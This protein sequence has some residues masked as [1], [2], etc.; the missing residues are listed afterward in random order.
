[1]A[2]RCTELGVALRPHVKTHK[3]I[4]IG[5]YQRAFGAEG[6]TVSTLAEARAFAEHGFDDIVWAYPIQINRIP[7]AGLLADEIKLGVVAD[8]LNAIEALDKSGLPLAVHLKIDCGYHR[9]GLDPKGHELIRVASWA[10]Q[11]KNLECG[12]LL[13]HSGHSYHSRDVKAVA[14]D[15]R[16]VILK[17]K[18]RLKRAGMDVCKVS[19]GSTPAMRA[20]EDLSGIDEVRPGNYA[21]FDY[22]QLHMGS[23]NIEDCAVSV[24]TT[25]ISTHSHLEHSIIDAGALALGKD[26]GPSRPNN[27]VYAKVYKDYEAGLLYDDL[28]VVGLSQEHGK[29]NSNLNHDQKLRLLP[30]HSCLT[31]AHF[32]SMYVAEGEQVVDQWK[33]WRN[34]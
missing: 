15:E 27:P 22:D 10:S 9:A 34:R 25:V 23:C 8:S 11:S 12:G 19:I 6:I 13:S 7:E 21:L 2:N 30:N 4:E 5:E 3:C 31:V 17:T 28:N 29:I 24:I 1:M 20:V 16:K 14:D 32:D 18:E 26:L 33:I